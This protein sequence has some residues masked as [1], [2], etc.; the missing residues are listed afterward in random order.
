MFD[1][2]AAQRLQGASGRASNKSL[3]V[4]LFR[5]ERFL[6][7]TCLLLLTAA[8]PFEPGGQPNDVHL[9]VNSCAGSTCH[10]MASTTKKYSAV[11]Q[12]EYLTWQKYD[13]HARAFTALQS[14]L[15]ER[16]ATGLGVGPAERAPMCLTCH[17]DN[18]T[19]ENR[20]V[21][22]HLS[23]GVGCEACHGGSQKWLGPHVSGRISHNDL[24]R[25]DG[26]YPTDRPVERAKLCLSC[27]L[28]DDTRVMTH[29]IMGAGHPR[30]VFELQTFTQIEPAHYVIDD[31][32]KRRKAASQGVQF[33]AIGQAIALQQLVTGLAENQHRD[34]AFPELVFFDCQACHHSTGTLRWQRRTSMGLGPGLPHF[35]DANAIMLRAIAARIAPDL[36]RTLEIQI[37]AL[38]Q[39]MSEGSGKPADLAQRVAATAGT[40][41]DTLGTHLFSAADMQAMIVALARSARDGDASDY[42]AA[43]QSTMAFASIIY[44]LNT[45]QALTRAQYAALRAGLDRCYAATRQPDSYDPAAFAAAAQSV[46][47]VLSAS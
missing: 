24:V 8:A 5:K 47:Q 15:G 12:N 41:A 40:L 33:W 4:L 9:G 32:Y 44:T 16:I 31:I 19:P 10:G 39:A 37:R 43:E 1:Q 36:A 45:E 20:G 13:K 30:L 35:N 7:L 25:D 22:F 18:V 42:A 6:P 34:G 27:H 14:P 23:D 29:R 21:E 3:L 17:A 2:A 46:A 28:G 38:H 11:I 26:L